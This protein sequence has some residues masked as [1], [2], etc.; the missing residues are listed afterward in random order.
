MLWEATAGKEYI[1][2]LGK[3]VKV[4]GGGSRHPAWPGVQA[5]VAHLQKCIY[6]EAVRIIHKGGDRQKGASDSL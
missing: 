3:S 6:W 5:A 4:S 2:L 1:W